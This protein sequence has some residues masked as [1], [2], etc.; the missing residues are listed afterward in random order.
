VPSPEFDVGWYQEIPPGS[1]VF[2]G[3]KYF[4]GV[5]FGAG[6]GQ[7]PGTAPGA[8][9]PGVDGDATITITE[10]HVEVTWHLVVAPG[11]GSTEGN[12]LVEIS[13]MGFE[14]GVTVDFDG[15]PA[16]DVTI[17]DAYHLTCV[18]PAHP[19]GIVDVTVTYPGP[20]T[21]VLEEG[22]EYRSSKIQ[23]NP[24]L[25]GILGADPVDIT[26]SGLPF[27]EGA[28][29]TFDGI[30]AFVVEVVDPHHITCRTPPHDEG[31][32]TV[33]VANPEG[34]SVFTLL[35]GFT[36]QELV[37]SPTV[38]AGETAVAQG[39]APS[40]VATNATVRRGLNNGTLT[41]QWVEGA[42]NP[43]VSTISDPNSLNTQITFDTYTPGVYQYKLSV[44]DQGGRFVGE[45]TTSI[46]IPQ[47]TPPKLTGSNQT[48]GAT[49]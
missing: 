5:Y 35:N 32:V 26:N 39:P 46:V 27:E 42:G 16:T 4:Y 2:F 44:S 48:R 37:T 40:T 8:L 6:T 7:T 1:G 17:V 20:S 43:D 29:V 13:G 28:S 38:S 10:I 47:P 18:T 22:Y 41:F 14:E 36:Y 15:I 33:Q 31:L 25:G 3:P 9:P 24:K 12:E 23:I 19:D 49:A 34:G 45:S 30:D 21:E 11:I